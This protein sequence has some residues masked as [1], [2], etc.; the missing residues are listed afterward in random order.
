MFNLI[1]PIINSN[2]FPHFKLDNVLSEEDIKQL[3]EYTKTEMP[4]EPAQYITDT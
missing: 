2:P 3:D 1:P 4:L